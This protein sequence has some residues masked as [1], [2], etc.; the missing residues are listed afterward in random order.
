MPAFEYV[1]LDERGKQKKGVLEGDSARQ[2]RQQLKEK[3]MVPLSVETTSQKSDKQDSN[4]FQFAK[5]SISAGDLAIITR[6]MAT[7]LQAGL[8]LEEAL[9]AVSRQ[10]E[11]ASNK[12]MMLAIR[13]KVVEGHTLAGSLNEFPRSFPEL[14]RATV[15]AG[16]HSGHLDLVLEQL[17]DYTEARYRTKKKVQGA[18]IYPLVLTS[19]AFLIVAGMLT[20]VVP[21]IVSVFEDSGQELP[22]LTRILIGASELLQSWWWLL[23]VLMVAAVFGFKRA[24]KNEAFRFRF[25]AWLLKAP[26][27]GKITRGLDASRVAST[28][29]ILSKSGVPLVDAMKISGQVAG[30]VCIRESVT[31]GAD[32]LKEGSSLFAALDGSGYFPPMMMQMIASGERSGELDSMLA[33]AATNQERELEDLIDTIVA[34]FEPLMLVVMGGVVM[35]IVL[36]IMMP[37]LSMNS[38][39]G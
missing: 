16:E 28:L 4:K 32:K 33:R 14:Y 20:F 6:Q 8:P 2:V 11:K 1:V 13:A 3:G 38:L 22:V 7:L 19:F 17:A 9:K 29:S 27:L 26:L 37:I 21:K 35:I 30:N 18:M 12:S 31:L 36:S 10:Q 15:A 5:G 34:L 39:V 24:L 23:I 25:H